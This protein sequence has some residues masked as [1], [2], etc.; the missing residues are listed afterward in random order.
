MTIEIATEQEGETTIVVVS[1][2]LDGLTA[3]VLDEKLGAAIG[4]TAHTIIDMAG[5]D[6]VS[7]AGLR[8]LLK[9]A[10]QAKARGVRLALCAMHP[11]VREVFDI[12]GFSSIF[13]IFPGR[14]EAIAA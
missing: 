11:H 1:G 6:Y 14:H 7:S 8:I 4:A 9:A 13:A 12:S 3:P 10:K 2:R 5:L